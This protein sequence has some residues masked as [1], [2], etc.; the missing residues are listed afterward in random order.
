VFFIVPR[1]FIYCALAGW[2]IERQVLPE[3]DDD[4]EPGAS[5]ENGE[6]AVL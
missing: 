5:K 6:L 2:A 4:A 1:M 3:S